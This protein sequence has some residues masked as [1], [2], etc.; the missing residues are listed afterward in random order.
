MSAKPIRLAGFHLRSAWNWRTT[1]YGRV[2][3]A[4]FYYVF[5]V[6]GLS[7]VVQPEIDGIEYRRFAFAGVL[8]IV[9]VRVLFW[10][11]ADVAN[12]RKW[13]VYA[14]AR[15]SGLSYR[16]Y[17][18][19]IVL[20]AC[21]IV[22]VQ[23]LALFAARAAIETALSLDELASCGIV[24]LLSPIPIV[25]GAGLGFLI[26]SYARRDLINSL[27]GLPL[28]VTAPLFYG[29]DAAPAV[30]RALA[31]ANPFSY[32]SVVA[33]LPLDGQDAGLGVIGSMT[34]G[35]LAVVLVLVMSGR[36][37]LISTEAG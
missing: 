31:Y 30:L 9:L 6:L 26:N 21:A 24:L 33:R 5:L 28:V 10:T 29:L 22:T 3:E 12:D 1:H 13:G 8:V 35:F 7:G 15:G 20:A 14:V 16:Q 18:L 32:F 4:P 37:E 27:L 34:S 23:V 36:H 11:M 25:A 2:L 17:V 19:S